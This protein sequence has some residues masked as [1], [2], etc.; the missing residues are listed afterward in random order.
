MFAT[1]TTRIMSSIILKNRVESIAIAIARQFAT[2]L[3][4]KWIEGLVMEHE[5]DV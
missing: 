4:C 3:N 5:G 1:L 2:K